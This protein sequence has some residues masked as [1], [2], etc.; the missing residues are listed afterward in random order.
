MH[1]G[2][3]IWDCLKGALQSRMPTYSAIREHKIETPCQRQRTGDRFLLNITRMH[4]LIFYWW[5]I[6]ILRIWTVRWI[7]CCCSYTLG[8][9]AWRY[10]AVGLSVQLFTH[11]DTVASVANP[12]CKIGLTN[13]YT[14]QTIRM[15]G[16]VRSCKEILEKIFQSE[17]D[18]RRDTS[19][20]TMLRMLPQI[21]IILPREN[22]K[23]YT[24][25]RSAVPY[26][27]RIQI[28]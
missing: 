22:D 3:N 15:L 16:Q 2:L 9:R 28:F 1:Y 8:L 18:R 6:N 23:L 25:K 14:L 4:L 13:K 27:L 10:L 17:I 11:G 20:V 5:M 26:S 24:R 19:Q 7:L 12:H 21:R